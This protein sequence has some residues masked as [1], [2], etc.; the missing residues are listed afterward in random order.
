LQQ[1]KKLAQLI[2]GRHRAHR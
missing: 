1:E 2:A